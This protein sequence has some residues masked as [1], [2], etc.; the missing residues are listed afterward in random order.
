MGTLTN[1]TPPRG[2][3]DEQ[4]AGDQAECAADAAHRGVHAH[5]PVAARARGERRGDQRQRGGRDDRTARALDDPGCQQPGLRGGEPAGERRGREQHQARHEHPA[6]SE[7]VTG[8]AAEQQQT[9]ERQR[10]RVDHPLQA[11]ARESE[12]RLNMRQRDVDDGRVQNDHQLR[13][14][15]GQQRQA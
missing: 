10:V 3:G 2:V 12:C 15:D 14:R 1:I 13:G 6:P 4:A 8:A 5:R 7:Q 11:A 9:A